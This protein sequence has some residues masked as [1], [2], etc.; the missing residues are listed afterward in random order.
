MP[1]YTYQCL[2]CGHV[3]DLCRPYEDRNL[4]PVCPACEKGGMRRPT[5][6]LFATGVAIIIRKEV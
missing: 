4:H 2:Y 1:I 3:F 5:K 6:R